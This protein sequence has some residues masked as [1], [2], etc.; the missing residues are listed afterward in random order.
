M[1]VRES[2]ARGEQGNVGVACVLV[3]LSY[4]DNGKASSIE[5]VKQERRVEECAGEGRPQDEL[6]D[7]NDKEGVKLVYPHQVHDCG[8]NKEAACSE[9][10]T[11]QSIVLSLGLLAAI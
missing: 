11:Q 9:E 8:G 6:E 7:A 1:S 5:E 4:G 2:R 10:D 3:F